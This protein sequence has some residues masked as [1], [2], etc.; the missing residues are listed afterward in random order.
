MPETTRPELPDLAAAISAAMLSVPVE[1]Q[2][3]AL[4]LYRHLADGEPV[5]A[6]ALA[7]HLDGDEA[8]IAATL[9]RWPGVY[10]SEAGH[11]VAF[12]GLAIP[13]MPHRF[14]IDGRQLYTW[15][16]WDALF[17]PELIGRTAEVESRSPAS[18]ERV[19]LTVAP[20]RVLAVEPRQA[21]VSM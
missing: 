10:R 18:G 19:S 1:E 7:A 11:V 15:C 14:R 5:A 6:A 4:A 8:E 9:E 13:E 12:G 2:R 3:L 20:E 16:A 21:V 17:I